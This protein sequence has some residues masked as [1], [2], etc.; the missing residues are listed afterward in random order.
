MQPGTAAATADMAIRA[1]QMAGIG[2]WTWQPGTDRIEADDLSREHWGLPQKMPLTL[3]K[4]RA[5]VHADDLPRLDAA[6]SQCLYN[7]E[8]ATGVGTYRCRQVDGRERSLLFSAMYLPADGRGERTV[9]GISLDLTDRKEYA[10]QLQD[11]HRRLGARMQAQQESVA[12]AVHDVRNDLAMLQSALHLSGKVQGRHFALDLQ[13]QIG[14]IALT[15][16]RLLHSFEAEEEAP[17]QLSSP[18]ERV[19]PPQSDTL[20]SPHAGDSHPR[21]ILVA[22]DNADAAKALALMLRMDGHDVRV[23]LN[24][25]EALELAEESHPEVLLLDIAMPVKDGLT[26]AREIKAQ[27]W[28]TQ[29]ALIAMSGRNRPED[30]DETFDAG[31]MQ[32]LVKP[33]NFDEVS[34]LVAGARS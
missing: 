28:G 17:E 23:A 27:P 2:R 21:R 14:R 11:E 15:M 32:H 19:Q 6:L 16:N 4:L 7:K 31:F 5:Q 20:S 10:A 34:R 29:C 25:Q 18:S 1:L 22:D 24:G 3:S 26:V 13:A 30:R 12:A 33:L 9:L 8:S